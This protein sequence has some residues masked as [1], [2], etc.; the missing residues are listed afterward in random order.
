[1]AGTRDE[2]QEKHGVWGRS[3]QA[4]VAGAEDYGCDTTGSQ[5]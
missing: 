2:G 1:M 4:S 5:S 3:K